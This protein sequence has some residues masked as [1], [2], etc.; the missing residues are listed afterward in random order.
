MKRTAEG[1]SRTARAP[2]Q[3]RTVASLFDSF[4]GDSFNGHASK[5][6]VKKKQ[7]LKPKAVTVEEIFDPVAEP[8]KR[9]TELPTVS[10]I[11]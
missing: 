1:S 2:K 6:T 9:T 10:D 7:P 3:P 8:A 11:D 4:L 5:K